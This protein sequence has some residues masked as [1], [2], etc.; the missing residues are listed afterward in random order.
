MELVENK[1]QGAA[2]TVFSPRQS[3]DSE[4]VQ[5]IHKLDQAQNP[6]AFDPHRTS[7]A[8][9]PSCAAYAHAHTF[10]QESLLHRPR[11]SDFSTESI[12]SRMRTRR[13]LGMGAVGPKLM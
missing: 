11:W 7:N 8:T 6:I 5:T 12:S 13:L 4:F 10:Q 2:Q 3:A 9:F 1:I